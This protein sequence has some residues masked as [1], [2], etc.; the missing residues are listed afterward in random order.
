[1]RTPIEHVSPR[2]P[3]S[4]TTF[5]NSSDGILTQHEYSWS[6]MP[7]CS[8]SMSMSLSSNSD[9]RLASDDSN[10]IDSE[11]DSAAE[12]RVTE[13]SLPIDLREA[14]RCVSEE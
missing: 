2:A 6:G 12:D 14:K 8:D 4:V 9:T 5:L 13:S 11:S 7:K 3:T 10:V 1:M